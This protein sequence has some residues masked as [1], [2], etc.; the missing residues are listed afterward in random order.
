[1]IRLS[2]ALRRDVRG[3]AVIEIAFTAPLLLL[4]ILGLFEYA[5]YAVVRE[6]LSQAA[7]QIADNAARLGEARLTG[8]MPI[9]EKQINDVLLGGQ[10]QGSPSD[11]QQRGR[12]ILTSL[13]RNASQGQWRHWQR[14][15]GALAHPS[16]WGVEGDG[17]TGQ[18]ADGM[19]PANARI[20]AQDG[21]PVQFV[22][23][24]YAYRPLV[25]DV[26]FASP[27]IVESAAVPVRADRNLDHVANDEKVTVSR[28]S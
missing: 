17:A 9:S 8:P 26:R 5:R 11:L 10:I 14:C 7:F 16:S 25:F 21:I 13:E 22:E 27:E 2:K 24:A 20:Q 19:G 4:L 3:V 15:V 1:M 28:C 12:I 18:T 23:L 6:G